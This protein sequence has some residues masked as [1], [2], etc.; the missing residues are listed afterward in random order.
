M[1]R[2]ER[3]GRAGAESINAP[4][5]RYHT[6]TPRQGRAPLSLSFYPNKVKS[7]VTVDAFWPSGETGSPS[8]ATK[9]ALC[10]HYGITDFATPNYP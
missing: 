8:L 2:M 1:F 7:T 4:L 10:G 9:T 3:V 5:S 6:S